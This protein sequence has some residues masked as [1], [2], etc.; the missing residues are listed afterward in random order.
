[1][2]WSLIGIFL[3]K[4]QP[5]KVYI[6]F[7]FFIQPPPQPSLKDF[8]ELLKKHS[9]VFHAART[10]RCLQQQWQALKQYTLLPD[11]SVQPLPR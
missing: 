2:N 8:E 5:K 10:P 6:L 11:Q 7:F 1:M 4:K 9:G 3:Y